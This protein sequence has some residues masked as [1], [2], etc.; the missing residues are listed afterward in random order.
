MFEKK[1]CFFI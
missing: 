1:N